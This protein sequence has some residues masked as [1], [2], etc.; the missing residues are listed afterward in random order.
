MF[1]ALALYTSAGAP[2]TGAAPTF[3]AFKDRDGAN[4]SQPVVSELGGGLYG[5][6]TS[7]ADDAE[8][9]AY[10]VDGGATAVPRYLSGTAGSADLDAFA[11]YDSSQAPTASATPVFASYRSPTGA[12]LTPPTITN[13]GLGLYG[14]VPA[15]DE[16]NDGAAYEISTGA[17]PER[18]FGTVDHFTVETDSALPDVAAD[19]AAYLEGAGLGLTRGT[20]LFAA[21]EVPDFADTA[22]ANEVYVM[23]SGGPAPKPFLGTGSSLHQMSASVLIRG[24]HMTKTSAGALAASVLRALHLAPISGYVSVLARDALPV[25]LSVEPHD[26]PG[27]SVGVTCLF[28]S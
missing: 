20:N 21:D 17:Y 24:T 3:V 4:R 8:G 26:A 13:L 7:S 27:W 14:F 22:T 19:I 1:V 28:Q 15:D 23:A 25:Y 9:V 10:L 16:L 12:S 2:L 18:L 5:F 11:V 6:S